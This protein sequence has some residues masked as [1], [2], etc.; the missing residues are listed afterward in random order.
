MV[1]E[2]YAM[3]HSA[4]MMTLTFKQVSWALEVGSMPGS[5]SADL[6]FGLLVF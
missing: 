6:A 4:A 2:K 3:W 1:T 5:R